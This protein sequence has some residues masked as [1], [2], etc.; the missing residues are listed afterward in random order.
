MSE[1]KE[2]IRTGSRFLIAGILAALG[3]SACCVGPLVLL[4]LG[5]S[6]AWIGSLTALEPYRPVFM[7][8]TLLF[9][10]AAFHRLYLARQVCTPGSACIDPRALKRQRVLFW[11]VAILALGLISAPWF[12]PLFY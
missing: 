4:A 1:P 10:A 5:I 2:S 12:V 9:L 6:G 7:G 11:I 3:A 8:L